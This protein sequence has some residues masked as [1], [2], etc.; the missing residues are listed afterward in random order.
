MKDDFNTFRADIDA[1]ILAIRAQILSL[2]SKIKAQVRSEENPNGL[3]IQDQAHYL[4]CLKFQT[5]ELG[6]VL[7]KD[8]G[9]W[10]AKELKV[11]ERVKGL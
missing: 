2:T 9:Y 4:R 10:E 6:S 8:K 5:E 11:K 3:L 7:E 1:D